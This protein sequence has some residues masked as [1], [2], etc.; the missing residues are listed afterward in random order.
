M[1]ELLQDGNW[2]AVKYF[3]KQSKRRQMQATLK[4]VNG[5]EIPAHSEAEAMATH[6]ETIQW[7]LR[8]NC[9]GQAS[10]MIFDTCLQTNDDDIT[11]QELCK[12]IRAMKN[13][14][15][16]GSDGIPPELWK[17]IAKDGEALRYF[18]HLYNEYWRSGITP[19]SW[20]KASVV[21]LFKKGSASDMNNYRPISLL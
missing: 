4:D 6:L 17:T 3:K 21:T 16:A 15:A 5:I 11:M 7:Y 13:Q 19:K 12:I 10:H 18:W 1:D 2:N 9:G 20:H 8:P 14:K